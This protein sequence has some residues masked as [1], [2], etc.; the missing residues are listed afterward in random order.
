MVFTLC[1]SSDLFLLLKIKQGGTSDTE[2]IGVY[3]FYNLVYAAAAF[4]FGILADRIGLKKIFITGLL[5]FTVVYAGMSRPGNWY[6]YGLL[7]F[8]YGL[9]AAATEGISKAWISNISSK[10]D[11][12]TAI[13]TYTGLQSIC[14]LLASTLSGW[15]WFQFGAATAFWTCAIMSF[16]VAVYLF[17]IVPEPQIKKSGA[18]SQ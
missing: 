16:L 3:I 10:D 18:Q 13:G 6:W 7:F 5:L 11:T 12:A 9:Y 14:T 2:T 8:L 17:L 4:P 1:N 15:L